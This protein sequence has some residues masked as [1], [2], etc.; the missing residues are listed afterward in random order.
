MHHLPARTAS[1]LA[2]LALACATAAATA[3]PPPLAAAEQLMN[4]GESQ[5]PQYF[6]GHP[7]TLNF[8]PFRYRLYAN[9][10]LLGVAVG[11]DPKYTQN[12]VYVLGGPFGGHDQPPLFVGTLSQYIT[13]TDPGPGPT[14]NA[15]GCHD[16]N[17]LTTNGNVIS[18]SYEWSGPITGTSTV[19]NAILSTTTFEGQPATE[20]LLRQRGT[21]FENGLVSVFDNT[22]KIYLRKTGTA[23]I[24]FH[25]TASASTVTTNDYIAATNTTTTYTPLWADRTYALAVG[26]SLKIGRAHV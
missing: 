22:E 7:V 5:F 20:T 16:L 11:A 14:G 19:D 21:L 15:N 1:L 13:P 10:V 18:I 17:L 2:P 9:G 25:G 12:G 4:F 24:T 6:P 23:E 26:E 8:G 3:A